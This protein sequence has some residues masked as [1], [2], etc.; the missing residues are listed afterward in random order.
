MPFI[1]SQTGAI[2]DTDD[3]YN[4]GSNS[5]R[6]AEIFATTLNTVNMEALAADLAENYLADADYEPGTVLV[7]G[8]D[9]EVTTT[10]KKG[11]T[12]VAGVV[13]TNPA[14]IM[15]SALEGEYVTAI[16]L[17]GRVP[18][19]VLG[20]VKKGDIL[21]SAGISG[22]A[23]ATDNPATGTIIGKSLENKETSDKGVIEV[24]VGRM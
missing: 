3:T 16:A 24:A 13:T 14:T 2:P 8:G 12:R 10:T 20:R 4:I 18:C 5:R 6:Y 1:F 9:Y 21:V 7:F 23:V 19:K 22:Y 15:N 17:Q 11:D